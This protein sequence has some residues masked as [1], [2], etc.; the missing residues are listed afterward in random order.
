[1][2][3][4]EAL[5][6]LATAAMLALAQPAAAQGRMAGHSGR[7]G[8]AALA[9]GASAPASGLFARGSQETK[10]RGGLH[11]RG[12]GAR[13]AFDHGRNAA[14]SGLSFRT[15]L[16]SVDSTA[17]HGVGFTSSGVSEWSS[18]GG[19]ASPF[20]PGPTGRR[21]AGSPFPPGPNTPGPWSGR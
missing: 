15:E 18:P 1:M 16:D 7:G 20:P 6:G 21:G 4:T 13:S 12:H 3:K 19:F 17:L 10:R 2:R 14:A 9:P 5:L 11:R 8:G